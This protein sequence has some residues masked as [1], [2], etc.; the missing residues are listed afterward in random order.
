MQQYTETEIINGLKTMDRDILQ[1]IVEEYYPSVYYFVR[2]NRGREED[3]ED[4]FQ[5]TMVVIFDK[6]RD[7]DFDLKCSLKT[8]IYAVSRNI[9]LKR[10]IYSSRRKQRLFSETDDFMVEECPSAAELDEDEKKFLFQRNFLKLNEVCR[11]ILELFLEQKSY[12][13]ISDRFDL[14]GV[15]SARKKKYRC[16][17]SLIRFIKNDP[18]YK[19]MI[20]L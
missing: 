10:L 19:R 8:F 16:L 15:Q 14:G 20:Q 1:Y 3:A 17:Q 6:I 5:D 18:E 13:Y 7:G 2:N 4:I 11:M 9:W 12:Q